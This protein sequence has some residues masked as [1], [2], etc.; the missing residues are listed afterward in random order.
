MMSTREKA[1]QK[2]TTAAQRSVHDTSFLWALV[3]VRGALGFP[4]LPDRDRRTETSPS[5]LG[6]QPA[7]RKVLAGYRRMVP[8]QSS[9]GT[10]WWLAGAVTVPSGMPAALT[11]GE[12]LSL[13][14]PRAAVPRPRH[15]RG[16]W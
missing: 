14:L 5:D 10:S 13:P 16:L 12:F 15:R 7:S 4:A 11:A 9:S 1:I 6:V 8:A 3:A 2:A